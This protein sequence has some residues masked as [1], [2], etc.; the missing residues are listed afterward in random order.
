MIKGPKG[1]FCITKPVFRPHLRQITKITRYSHAQSSR[2]H[3]LSPAN[4]RHSLPHAQRPRP[5]TPHLTSRIPRAWR[6]LPVLS[7]I[8]LKLWKASYCLIDIHA[9]RILSGRSLTGTSRQLGGA[10]PDRRSQTTGRAAARQA[11]ILSIWAGGSLTGAGKTACP[12]G[13]HMAAFVCTYIKEGQGQSGAMSRSGVRGGAVFLAS[14][15]S[16]YLP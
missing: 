7:S 6:I 8:H 14:G 11:Q 2:H 9:L 15:C 3:P 5:Q 12:A 16:C 13:T 10:Q 1:P 4:P